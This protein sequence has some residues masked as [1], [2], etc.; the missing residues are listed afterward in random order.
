MRLNEHRH[1]FRHR[2]AKNA[3][4]W[5]IEC[6]DES[7]GR[8]NVMMG[9]VGNEEAADKMVYLLNIASQNIMQAIMIK[10]ENPYRSVK[11]NG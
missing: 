8:D 1:S 6:S 5:I 2:K 11:K 10:E 3:E 9:I 4:F 7:S